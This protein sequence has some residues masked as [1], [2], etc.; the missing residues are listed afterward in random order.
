[1]AKERIY[2]PP[3]AIM[4]YSLRY[5]MLLSKTDDI[6]NRE[7]K[8]KDWQLESLAMFVMGVQLGD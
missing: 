3:Y 4:A 6:F 1:M 5:T 2:F 7:H 8:F